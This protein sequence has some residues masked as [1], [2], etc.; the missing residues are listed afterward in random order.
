MH[1][2]R[3]RRGRCA[4][5]LAR[6]PSLRLRVGVACVGACARAV[7]RRPRPVRGRSAPRHRH[8][9]FGERGRPCA[10]RRARLLRRD[11]ARRRSNGH[12]ADRGRLLGH[13]SAPR[14]ARRTGRDLGRGR[15]PCRRPR[16]GRRRGLARAVDLPR[17]PGHGRAARIRRPAHAAP[18]SPL[19]RCRAAARA[20]ARADAGGP[21]PGRSV[22]G[23]AVRACGARTCGQGAD[24]QATEASCGASSR[25]HGDVGFDASRP[26]R[27]ACVGSA[28]DAGSGWR[29]AC[30]ERGGAANGTEAG[31]VACAARGAARSHGRTG[32]T[33]GGG[34]PTGGA[35]RAPC[36]ECAANIRAPAPVA[37]RSRARRVGA[38]RCRR[39]VET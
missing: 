3:A 15:R 25:A 6:V 33:A 32:G 28:A 7:P 10:G 30:L 12:A 1:A 4:R 13:A 29:A 36:S 5:G 19:A 31:P 21:V 23:R 34:D 17:R 11:G 14:A 24:R 2:F 9:R 18:A 26:R 39:R 16:P 35:E 20:R 8:R 37:L 22:T 38:M 27:R